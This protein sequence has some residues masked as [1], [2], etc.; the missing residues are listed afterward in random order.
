MRW[1]IL[2]SAIIV[3]LSCLSNTVYNIWF[4]RGVTEQKAEVVPVD[5]IAN[6]DSNVSHK[7]TSTIKMDSVSG[8]MKHVSSSTSVK[9]KQ[10]KTRER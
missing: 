4:S 1:T 3:A 9:P 5:T 7:D 2:L 10:I 6:V 8:R